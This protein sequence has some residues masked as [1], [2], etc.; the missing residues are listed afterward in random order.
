MSAPSQARI[1]LDLIAVDDAA[2][3]EPYRGAWRGLKLPRW[4][5]Q[6]PTVLDSAAIVALELAVTASALKSRRFSNCMLAA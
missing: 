3:L 6:E 2:I 1:T 4:L 5:Q